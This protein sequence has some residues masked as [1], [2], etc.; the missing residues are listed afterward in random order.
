MLDGIGGEVLSIFVLWLLANYDDVFVW[1][2]L[3]IFYYH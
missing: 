3:V 1:V 2:L